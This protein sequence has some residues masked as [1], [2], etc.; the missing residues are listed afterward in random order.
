V[1]GCR[2]SAQL[3]GFHSIWTARPAAYGTHPS[4]PDC[5]RNRVARSVAGRIFSNRTRPSLRN[6]IPGHPLI[7]MIRHLK[8]PSIASVI[9][10][11]GS[12]WA[13]ILALYFGLSAVYRPA[14]GN[15]CRARLCWP[16]GPGSRRHQAVPA[17]VA[18]MAEGGERGLSYSHPG[19]GGDALDALCAH[20][21]DATD[22]LDRRLVDGML[23]GRSQ[24]CRISIFSAP[25]FPSAVR[26]ARWWP[27][28]FMSFLSGRF[29]R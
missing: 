19:C 3:S 22:R 13:M 9:A 5:D 16:Y 17:D 14:P 28:T 18:A 11:W 12:A 7:P 29:L 15:V 6:S 23:H 2:R 20:V 8:R 4:Q 26:S 25:A 10:H 27:T 1:R 21:A 24:G